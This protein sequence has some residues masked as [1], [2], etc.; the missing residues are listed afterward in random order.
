MKEVTL[1]IHCTSTRVQKG[2]KITPLIKRDVF[3]WAGA[4][5]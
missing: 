4:A 5:Q 2:E 1:M 3:G